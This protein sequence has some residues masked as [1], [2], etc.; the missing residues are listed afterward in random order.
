MKMTWSELLFAH[1]SVAPEVVAPRLP[2]G[3]ELDTFDGRAWLGVVPFRMSG[4]RMQ[5]WPAFGFGEEFPELNLRTYVRHADRPGVWFFSLDAASPLAVAGARAWFQL[6]Y[7]AAR[8]SCTSLADGSVRYSSSRRHPGAPS[9]EF[10]A[11][12]QPTSD[13]RTAARG[14]LEHF[15]VERYC[16]Y[17]TDV[18]GCLTRGEIAHAPWPIRDARANVSV[19]TLARASGFELSGAPQTLHFV[20]SIDVSAWAPVR[21]D[22]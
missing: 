11:T 1:W 17:S 2:R 8:M 3:L 13:P 14:S 19:N 15:L 22:E 7:F 9:A 16:L 5:G 20:R 4:V 6:P 18:G 10:E 21:A 12:Y